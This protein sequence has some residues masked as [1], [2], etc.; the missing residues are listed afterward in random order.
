MEELFRA[1]KHAH[2]YLFCGEMESTKEAALSCAYIAI[3]E[4]SNEDGFNPD[5]LTVNI[6]E[7]EQGISI[8][9]VRDIRRFLS[10]EP[11]FGSQ[12]VVVIEQSERMK[13]EASSALLKVLEEP[14]AKSAII[15]LSGESQLILGTILSRVQRVD[16]HDTKRK[17][18]IDKQEEICNTLASVILASPA[19]RFTKI[20]EMA[21]SEIRSD[22]FDHLVFFFHDMLTVALSGTEESLHYPFYLKQY[23][24]IVSRGTYTPERIAS[25]LSGLTEYA[26]VAKTTNANKRLL[27]ERI[28][29]LL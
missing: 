26:H 20:Q 25:I 27:L 5:L 12:R 18:G 24:N 17:Q 4:E 22:L 9:Q 23:Q 10:L 19:G 21:E 7:G 28:A 14:P 3:G 29:L 6:T 11:Y 16:F 2:A 13:N 1:G 8:D 15:L